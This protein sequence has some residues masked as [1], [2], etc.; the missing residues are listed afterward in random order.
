MPR[1]LGCACSDSSRLDSSGRLHCPRTCAPQE[2]RADPVEPA[3]LTGPRHRSPG[4]SS[5]STHSGGANGKAADTTTKNRGPT[6][7]QRGQGQA[8]S[9]RGAEGRSKAVASC[10]PACCV[11]R[12]PCDIRGQSRRLGFRRFANEAHLQCDSHS[13]SPVRIVGQPNDVRPRVEAEPRGI[14]RRSRTVAGEARCFRRRA[15]LLVAES[16]R[17]HERAPRPDQPRCRHRRPARPPRARAGDSGR[18]AAPARNFR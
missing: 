17:I 5:S 14:G 3:V 12:R 1:R 13:R 7:A 6:C 8:R 10:G 2:C 4:H 18:R 9:Q 15:R 11:E 16:H